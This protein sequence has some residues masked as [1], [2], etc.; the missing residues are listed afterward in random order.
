MGDAIVLTFAEKVPL[1]VLAASKLAGVPLEI[2]ASAKV[3]KGAAPT[4]V[5][6]SGCARSCW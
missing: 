6:P 5:F 4:L 3:A 1:A 2:D